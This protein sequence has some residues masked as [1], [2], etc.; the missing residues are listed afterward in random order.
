MTIVTYNAKVGQSIEPFEI[1]ESTSTD[2]AFGLLLEHDKFSITKDFHNLPNIK[3]ISSDIYPNGVGATIVANSEN[4]LATDILIDGTPYW[5]KVIRNNSASS[6][7]F[8]DGVL[9]NAYDDDFIYCYSNARLFQYKTNGV[10]DEEFEQIPIEIFPINSI[11][12]QASILLDGKYKAVGKQKDNIKIAYSRPQSD[13]DIV[14][15]YE[16]AECAN[17]ALDN[18]IISIKKCSFTID[19]IKYLIMNTNNYRLDVSEFLDSGFTLNIFILNGRLEYIAKTA[20]RVFSSNPLLAVNPTLSIVSNETVYSV[21]AGPLNKINQT[22]NN[23]TDEIERLLI[24]E[25]KSNG[26]LYLGTFTKSLNNNNVNLVT[27]LKQAN[28]KE[29]CYEYATQDL[30]GSAIV[31]YGDIT[32][33]Y[34]DVYFPDS[35]DIVYMDKNILV[36]NDIVGNEQLQIDIGLLEDVANLTISETIDKSLLINNNPYE[37][38]CSS[39]PTAFEDQIILSIDGAN[40]DLSLSSIVVSDR[41]AIIESLTLSKDSQI[42]TY[43]NTSPQQA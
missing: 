31:I 30:Y 34:K 43:I 12:N 28:L 14:F 16:V 1:K 26:G 41:I 36:H 35:S 4:I 37:I 27:Y 7:I 10:V 24:I 19:D 23:T 18:N 11:V 21:T 3:I 15:L 39:Y 6:E 38:N 25:A 32:H 29:E 20:D 5:Y 17:F 8:V 13:E 22:L 2:Q 42:Y 9:H 40:I 33:G